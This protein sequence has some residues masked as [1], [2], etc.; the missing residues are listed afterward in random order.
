VRKQE[1]K[2]NKR[3]CSELSV[4][5]PGNPWSE[6]RNVESCPNSVS[7]SKGLTVNHPNQHLRGLLCGIAIIHRS[8]YYISTSH[9]VVALMAT[10]PVK[11]LVQVFILLLNMIF[12]F[13]AMMNVKIKKCQHVIYRSSV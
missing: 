1:L 2:S 7:R 10:L 9:L 8:L 13:V 11:I 3:I 12:V 5:N 6:K 4:N